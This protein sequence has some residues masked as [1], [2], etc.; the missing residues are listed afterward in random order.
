MSAWSL[1]GSGEFEPWSE[2][3]D[4]WLLERASGDGRVVIVPTASSKE[5]DEVF[6]GWGRRGLEHFRRLGVPADVLPVRTRA[7][8]DRTDLAAR[9]ADASV[10]YVSGGNPSH[11]CEVLRDTA[12]CEALMTGLG[13]GMGYAGCSAGVAWLTETTYDSDAEDIEAIFR[14]GLGLVR[15]AL[16]GPHWDVIDTWVP[17]A[18]AFIVGSVADGHVFV[19]LD[20]RTAMLGDG[21]RW[22]VRG[23]GG[24]HVRRGGAFAS[25]V[26]GDRFELALSVD[27]S[28]AGD[29]Q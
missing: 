8:A 27:G 19:G 22:E 24:V 13:R 18:S 28:A 10:V 9:L 21:V 20:E 14:P 25:Y 7:D 5:G 26:E 16:F 11:L 17:G 2:V 6:D 23:R 29:G 15:E 1:L 4:R 12:V 3:A